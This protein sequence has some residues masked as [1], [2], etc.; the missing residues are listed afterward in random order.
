[1]LAHVLPCERVELMD[2]YLSPLCPGA[3]FA[4][5]RSSPANNDFARARYGIVQGDFFDTLIAP[6]R[7]LGVGSVRF[8]ASWGHIQLLPPGNPYDWS[9]LEMSLDNGHHAPRTPILALQ[10]CKPTETSSSLTPPAN[11]FGGQPLTRIPAHSYLCETM[12]WPLSIAETAETSCGKAPRGVSNE[13]G[14]SRIS[15][16]GAAG[17]LGPRS[18][19]SRFVEV[20]SGLLSYYLAR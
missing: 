20:Q 13:T 6:T 11:L 1:M 3:S 18:Q 19:L 17:Y 15:R 9:S 7:D 2:T 14:G 10:P 5:K 12:V 8:D 4:R 16:D